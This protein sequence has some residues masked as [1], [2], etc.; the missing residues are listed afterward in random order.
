MLKLSVQEAQRLR[1]RDTLVVAEPPLDPRMAA[2]LLRD[3]NCPVDSVPVLLRL[4]RGSEGSQGLRGFMIKYSTAT[5]RNPNVEMRRRYTHPEKNQVRLFSRQLHTACS[6]KAAPSRIRV[7][8]S[9][10]RPWHDP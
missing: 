5:K 2:R 3:P 10:S 9:A 6:S 1:D 4:A 8:R 7:C